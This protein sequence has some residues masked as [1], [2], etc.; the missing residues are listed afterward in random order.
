MS[1]YYGVRVFAEGRTALIGWPN[2]ATPPA[3]PLQV[4]VGYRPG[5]YNNLCVPDWAAMQGTRL[6]PL[7]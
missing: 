6:R 3:A 5:V 1:R 4:R 7:L 2:S